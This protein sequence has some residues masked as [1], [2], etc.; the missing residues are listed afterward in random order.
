MLEHPRGIPTRIELSAMLHDLECARDHIRRAFNVIDQY[1]HIYA[2]DEK[3]L[4]EIITSAAG[5]TDEATLGVG[6]MLAEDY[7]QEDDG[8]LD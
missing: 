4:A 8:E 5:K 3:E 7:P 6:R 2:K 1:S